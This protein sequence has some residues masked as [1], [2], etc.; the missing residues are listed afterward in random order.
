MRRHL[1]ALTIGILFGTALCPLANAQETTGT[2]GSPGATTTI[3]G[4]QLPPPDPQ[5]GGVI[6]D[7]ALQSTPWWAPR[8]VPPKG[9]P[10][11]LL[12]ITDDAGFGVPST[13]GGVIPTPTMDRI[14]NEGLRYNRVFST[15]LCSPTR[16]ALITGRNHHSAGFGVIS[17]Q[18]T[19]F[20]GYNSI[21][22]K[23]KATIGR[24]LLDNGYATAWFG[25]DHN[26]PAFDASQVGPFTRWPTGM[27]FEYFYGFVGGDANQWQ[28]NLF[29]NTTQI[30][31]FDRQTGLEPRYRDGGRRH[32][33]HLTD[34]PNRSQQADLYQIRARRHACAPPPDQGMGGQN[35]GDAPVRRRL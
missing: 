26:T 15:A 4:E 25:K 12:I 32:R 19:G 35:W 24:I 27:G 34:S 28:P 3:S 8:I 6:K 14:A 31:P 23:D 29:R 21:I 20:P 2:P 30:Y 5:F 11:V 13:F 18:S 17:E 9:A 10:N 16:A 7:D 22:N 1:A 33:L